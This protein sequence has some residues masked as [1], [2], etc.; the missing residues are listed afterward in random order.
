MSRHRPANDG[1]LTRK[2]SKIILDDH[3]S[4][5]VGSIIPDLLGDPN[6][7]ARALERSFLHSAR[8]CD[9]FDAQR[10]DESYGKHWTEQGLA[11]A[12][13]LNSTWAETGYRV[14]FAPFRLKE[15]SDGTLYSFSDKGMPDNDV[16]L[17]EAA[18]VSA[19]FPLILP[20]YSVVREAGNKWHFV[21]GG[22]AD[23]SG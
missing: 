21:D 18:V 15:S 12:L 20:P 19:R 5:I 11:P 3:F 4:P 6:A 23:S 7:R 1:A 17:M 9:T 16:K 10:L 13:V 8:S 2:I 22:Y 14:A